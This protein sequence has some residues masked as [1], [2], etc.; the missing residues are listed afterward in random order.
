MSRKETVELSKLPDFHLFQ[1]LLYTP[2]LACCTFA[3]VEV[4]TLLTST[5]TSQSILQYIALPGFSE[6]KPDHAKLN[7][8]FKDNN[9]MS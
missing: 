2:L 5:T 6:S 3:A 1:H 4:L 9:D 7:V 8:K